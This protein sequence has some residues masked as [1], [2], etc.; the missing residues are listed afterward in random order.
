MSG[1]ICILHCDVTTSTLTRGASRTVPENRHDLPA[2][3]LRSRFRSIILGRVPGNAT[4]NMV[5]RLSIG[6]R[7]TRLPNARQLRH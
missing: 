5:P 4:L 2:L 6:S 3:D 7:Q 1:L